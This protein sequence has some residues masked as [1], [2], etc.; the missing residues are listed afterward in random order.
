MVMHVVLGDG[1]MPKK[2]LTATL[3]DLWGKA[4]A[5]SDQF[6]FLLQAKAEPTATDRALVAWFV[7]NEIYYEVISGDADADDKIYDTAAETHSAKSLATTVVKLLNDKPEDGETADVLALFASD[8]P[9]A[10]EDRY[11]NEVAQAAVDAG[12][13][14][15]ALNDGMVEVDLTTGEEEPAAEPAEPVKKAAAKKAAAPAKKAAAKAPP[16]AAPEEAEE[17]P[18]GE[19]TRE[20]LEERTLDELKAIAANRGIELPPRTRHATYI[21][22]ILGA[23]F[24][25]GEPGEAVVE[26]VEEIEEE[27]SVNG[28]AGFD[29]GAGPALLV[30]ITSEGVIASKPCTNEL[31]MAVITQ[32]SQS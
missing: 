4:A 16:A 28:D 32:M 3:T 9:D 18:T 14:V 19:I 24:D 12:Y 27:I 25:A 31:A 6:W 22:R 15:F 13:S 8:D 11:L 17:E 21:D 5:E 10:E 2:E 7:A 30:I 29:F 26:E 20:F 1:E 23:D